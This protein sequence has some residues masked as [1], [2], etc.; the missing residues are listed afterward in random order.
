MGGCSLFALKIIG[1]CEHDLYLFYERI[2]GT[3][4]FINFFSFGLLGNSDWKQVCCC[5]PLHIKASLWLARLL[6]TSSLVS[7]I[8]I[9]QNEF[10]TKKMSHVEVIF[11]YNATIRPSNDLVVYCLSQVHRR[12]ENFFVI[13][14]KVKYFPFNACRLSILDL[15]QV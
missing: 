11:E 14:L 1:K 8:N 15:S 12:K 3:L 2:F 5:V 9:P 7:K 6:W 13:Y 4:W 10:W